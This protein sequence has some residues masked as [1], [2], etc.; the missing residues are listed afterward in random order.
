MG[1]FQDFLDNERAE[2]LKTEETQVSEAE[3]DAVKCKDCGSTDVTLKDGTYTC[4][5]CGNTWEDGNPEEENGEEDV[6]MDEAESELIKSKDYKEFVKYMVK[7][8]GYESF[9]DIPKDKLDDFWKVVDSK[10]NSKAEIG[11]DGVK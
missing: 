7:R 5:K 11:K 4:N 8:E 9:T 1:R 2:A 6:E 10:Y 3:A